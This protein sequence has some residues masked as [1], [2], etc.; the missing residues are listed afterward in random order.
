MPDPNNKKVK[1]KKELF[2]FVVF[3]FVFDPFP[4]TNPLK[5]SKK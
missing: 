5:P 3:V 1:K 2:F 4:E